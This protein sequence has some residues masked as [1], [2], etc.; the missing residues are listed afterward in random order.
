MKG[1]KHAGVSHQEAFYPFAP[2]P[3]CPLYSLSL[4]SVAPP[5]HCR[6]QAGGSDDLA[7]RDSSIIGWNSLMPVRPE[8]FRFQSLDRSLQKIFILETA[9]G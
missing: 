8:S 7:Q 3:L 5:A 4:C 6:K 1:K 2:L 9:S